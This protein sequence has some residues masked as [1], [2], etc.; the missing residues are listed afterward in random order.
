MGG[1]IAG[2]ERDRLAELQRSL[3]ALDSGGPASEAVHSA[4]RGVRLRLTRLAVEE[5][6]RRDCEQRARRHR[7]EFEQAL[8][9]FAER[10][11]QRARGS[12]APLALPAPAVAGAPSHPAA[13]MPAT[14]P[15]AVPAPRRAG[16]AAG[17]AKSGARARPRP[18]AAPPGEFWSPR[19]VL[20]FRMWE[21]RGRLQGAWRAWDR[22]FREA[23]CVSGRAERDDGDVPHTDG[24]CGEPPCGIYAF[25]E[26]AQLLASFGLPEGS[27]RN[28]YGLVA[29]S[30]K[31]VEHE[32]G[33]RGQ[34][35][36]VVAAAVVGRGLVVR[37][38]GI[39]R[40][41]ALFLAPE[42]AVAGLVAT[43]ASVVEE[44]G[45]PLEAAEAVIAYLSL[46]RDFCELTSP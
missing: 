17:R 34:R 37:V 36:R 33:Y 18:V 45:D 1:R 41:Q 9:G 32:R 31:V 23:R 5:L 6:I 4:G 22:P 14:A 27:R 35:A 29:L 8:L 42:D 12:T 10:A 13:P 25:K 15:V 16:P 20:G 30:G 3:R 43:D 39:E 7:E 19:A 2:S 24:R 40:L 11:V 26:P 46:A 21:V 44:V 28:A 38:E